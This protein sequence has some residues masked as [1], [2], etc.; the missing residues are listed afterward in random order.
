MLSIGWTEVTII[1]IIVVLVIGPK[2]L[3]TLLKQVGYFSKKIKSISREFNTSL[4]NLAKEAE[5]SEVK[6]SIDSIS[7]E[8]IKEKII[9]KAEIKSE[10]KDINTSFDKLKKNIDEIKKDSKID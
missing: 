4:N 5:I 8:N 2:E 6:K 3:P 1:F 9:K 10:F 7:N